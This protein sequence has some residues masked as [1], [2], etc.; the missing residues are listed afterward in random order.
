MP[1]PEK[2]KLIVTS[3]LH[4]QN[5]PQNQHIILNESPL[6]YA[7]H[8]HIDAL[9]K[10]VLPG[11]VLTIAMSEQSHGKRCKVFKYKNILFSSPLNVSAQ[12]IFLDYL[13]L[14]DSREPG[15]VNSLY[16][17]SQ[18]SFMSCN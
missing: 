11:P 13:T 3:S 16:S 8:I 18:V 12:E 5:T 7:F 17:D 15:H 1:P 9:L 6:T 4:F 2:S 10:G 14:G